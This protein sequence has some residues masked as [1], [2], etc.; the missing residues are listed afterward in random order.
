VRIVERN[1]NPK[2][3]FPKEIDGVPESS[4]DPS[5]NS[6]LILHDSGHDNHTLTLV[7]KIFLNPLTTGPFP[8]WITGDADDT[9]FIIENWPAAELNRFKRGFL[10][11]AKL[12]ND[13]FYLIPPAG[14]SALDVTKGNQTIRPNIY[15]HLYLDLVMSAAGSHTQIDLAYI[16][17]KFASGH[18]FRSHAQLYTLSDI[19]AERMEPIDERGRPRKKIRFLTVP[20]EIG[21]ALGLPHVG[22]SL[23]DPFCQLAIGLDGNSV[24]AGIL[25]K[26]SLAGGSNSAVCYGNYAPSSHANNVMGQGTQFDE[27][28]AAPWQ[29]RIAQHTR[30]RASDWKVVMQRPRPQ[31]VPVA[32]AGRR[33]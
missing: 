32:S 24:M 6:S 28:N 18:P 26:G 25:A 27:F 2:T 12:W 33:A 29:A 11:A 30:T 9:P 31:T 4:W 5:F 1:I 20:H 13:R 22:Q 21:H 10:S 17:P 7:L 16:A 3:K 23:N 15:C 8:Y 19:Q 14:F